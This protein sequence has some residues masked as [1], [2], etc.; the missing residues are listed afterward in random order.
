[1]IQYLDRTT[2]LDIYKKLTQRGRNNLRPITFED[3]VRSYLTPVKLV[4]KPDGVY[5]RYQ[6]YTSNELVNT[7]ILQSVATTGNE[8]SLE[9]YCLDMSL[10]YCF[11]E[12]KGQLLEL[13]AVLALREDEEQLFISLHE[14]EEL[15]TILKKMKSDHRV[16]SSAVNVEGMV[17]FSKKTGSSPERITVRSGPKRKNKNRD[18]SKT[19]KALMTHTEIE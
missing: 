8:L 14:I 10:R 2:P 1:M 19:V 18:Q 15:D 3:A 9:G 17:D 11:M 5:L 6:R 4:A 13:A 7:G 16:H 12:W